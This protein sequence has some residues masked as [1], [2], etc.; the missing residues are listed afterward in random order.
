MN[1]TNAKRIGDVVKIHT[2]RPTK[3][4]TLYRIVSRMKHLIVSNMKQ[5]YN[6]LYS[7]TNFRRCKI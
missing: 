6:P 7:Y 5:Q 3:Q 2:H 4:N 1:T